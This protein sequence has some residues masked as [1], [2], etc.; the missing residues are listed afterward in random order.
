MFQ[1]EAIE[2]RPRT[3]LLPLW[4]GRRMRRR[5]RRRRRW[6]GNR[7]MNG[8]EG[9]VEGN[10]GRKVFGRWWTETMT[11]LV[12]LQGERCAYSRRYGLRWSHDTHP[13]IHPPSWTTPATISLCFNDPWSCA[14]P[15]YVT[16][17]W[18]WQQFH[19]EKKIS[20][21]AKSSLWSSHEVFFIYCNSV[22]ET[23][24]IFANCICT[25]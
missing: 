17:T 14:E 11:S 7:E 10:D 3:T 9:R 19:L 1:C 22:I 8:G 21:L 25:N 4:E 15:K 5:R 12:L 24:T 16:K 23:T 13:P 18:W 2:A 6:T 20:H